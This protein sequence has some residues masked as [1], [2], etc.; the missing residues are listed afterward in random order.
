[1]KEIPPLQEALPS[2]E[3]IDQRTPYFK[4]DCGKCYTVTSKAP[5]RLFEDVL[6]PNLFF[7]LEDFNWGSSYTAG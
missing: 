7:L 3:E 4:S 2:V 6:T 5:H 1:M